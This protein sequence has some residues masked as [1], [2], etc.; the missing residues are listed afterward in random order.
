MRNVVTTDN[1][2][3][4]LNLVGDGVAWFHGI[5]SHALD[6]RNE[7]RNIAHAVTRVYFARR[8]VKVYEMRQ[9]MG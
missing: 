1:K 9:G 2:V 8:L 4:Y 7:T 3:L 6:F 5:Y